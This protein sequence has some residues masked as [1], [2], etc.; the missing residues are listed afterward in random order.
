MDVGRNFAEV[1]RA[2]DGLQ[3][4]AN[5]GIATPANWN[6]GDDVVIPTAVN[7]VGAKVKFGDF[8]TAQP[9]LRMTKL[10]G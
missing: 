4:A 2:Q 7:D 5:I 3:T 8:T 9:Y 1:M 6:V 10:K